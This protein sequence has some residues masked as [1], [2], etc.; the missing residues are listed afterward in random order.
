MFNGILAN[1]HVELLTKG[2]WTSIYYY[3]SKWYLCR[4]DAKGK[5]ELADEPFMYAFSLTSMEHDKSTSYPRVTTIVFDEFIAREA[6]IPDEFVLFANTLS[7]IIRQRNNVKII[8]LGNSVNKYCPYYTEMGLTHVRSMRPGDLEVYKYGQSGLL[9]A[10]EY[11]APTKG[12][13]RSDIYFAFDNPKLAMITEGEWELGVY[14]HCNVK[15]KPKHIVFT[16]F[17][18]FNDD[19]L[20]CEIINTGKENFT[21]IHRKTTDIR[22]PDKDFVFSTEYSPL[23]N[24]SRMITKPIT[25]IEKKIA[26]YFSKD[27]VFYQDNEVGDIVRNYINFCMKSDTNK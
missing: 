24:F 27:K 5:R 25:N 22:H 23:P 3:A 9:V 14:P 20:Q 19:I 8:M 16:Y 12:G 6:Y 26:W 1:N 18:K 13:K 15:Y 17:I 7:T 10:V 11:T 21:Y 2:Q 4:F